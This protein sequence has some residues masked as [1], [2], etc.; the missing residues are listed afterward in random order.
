MENKKTT[1]GD[2]WKT[3]SNV[4]VRQFVEKKMN[5][6]YLSWANAWAVLMDHYPEATF[7]FDE[8]KYYQ[9]GSVEINCTV[10]IDGHDRMM[11]LPVMDHRNNSISS[12]SSRQI[13]DAKM[14]CLTKCLALF[15]LG[16]CL[17]VGEELPRESSNS[18]SKSSNVS[19]IELDKRK[20]ESAKTLDDLRNR[21][22]SI[23]DSSKDHLRRF[24]NDMKKQISLQRAA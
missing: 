7:R 11:W 4:D 16:H 12:P 5:L 14:R 13:S 17:Y 6:S 3:L 20:L 23:P 2:I 19:P 1:F 24:A 9:D 10:N 18:P 8:P 22:E 15:G 21:W